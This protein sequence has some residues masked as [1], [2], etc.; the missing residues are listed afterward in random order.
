MSEVKIIPQ[1]FSFQTPNLTDRFGNVKS[2]GISITIELDAFRAD[3]NAVKKNLEFI[4]TEVLEYFDWF[5]GA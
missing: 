1:K 3:K 4:F 5:F 2:S